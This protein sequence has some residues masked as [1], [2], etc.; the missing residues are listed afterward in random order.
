MVRHDDAVL[1]ME[2]KNCLVPHGDHC[3]E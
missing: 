3:S 1:E 2:W